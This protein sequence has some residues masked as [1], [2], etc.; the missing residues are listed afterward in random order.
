MCPHTTAIYVSSYDRYICVLILALL[1]LYTQVL[2]RSLAINPRHT[3]AIYVSSYDRYICVLIL[4]L[5]LLYT[6][7]LKRSLAINPRHTD[8]LCALGGVS[9]DDSCKV[10]FCVNFF[11]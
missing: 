7:V 3:H 9:L 1:L 10:F 4:A 11:V 5:L 2:K 8:S 6:Q